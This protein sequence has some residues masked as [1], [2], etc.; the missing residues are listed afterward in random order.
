MVR[1]FGSL[2]ALVVVTGII[3]Y[4]QSSGDER[5]LQPALP[6]DQSANDAS[7]A[8]VANAF[9]DAYGGQPFMEMR[10]CQSGWRPRSLVEIRI[11]EPQSEGECRW[12]RDDSPLW[13]PCNACPQGSAAIDVEPDGTIICVKLPKG[14]GER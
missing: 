5:I 11:K 14:L 6:P 8:C 3:A 2:L 9:W 12:R 4:K 10:A 1:L 13:I 7:R